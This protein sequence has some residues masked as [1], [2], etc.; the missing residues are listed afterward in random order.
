MEKISRTY[1]TGETT[2]TALK[3][4]DF[5]LR[6]GELVVVLGHSGSG[7]S[8]FL[9]IMGALD[10]PTSGRLFF[11]SEDVFAK[12]DDQLTAFRRQN[13]GLVFQFYNLLP[14]L[15]ALENVQ[16]MESL[17][18]RAMPSEEALR[19]LHIW[20]RRNH[21]PSELSGGE[22]QRIAIARAIVKNP[23]LLLCDEPT[24]ALDV[25]TGILVLEAIEQVH[26]EWGVT[27]VLITHN[28]SIALLADRIVH[29]SGGKIQKIEINADHR[30]A[31]D[32]QW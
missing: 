15:T 22:Q 4:I 9:N 21:F 5:E 28:T 20:E 32:L 19:R 29:I 30:L 26:H 17:S 27:V 7:K 1:Q 14:T 6:R 31:R 11:E 12:R 10:R 16:L 18:E 25:Q 13:V 3:D 8:T 23:K 24:G 2:V